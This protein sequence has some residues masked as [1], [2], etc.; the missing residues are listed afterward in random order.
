V[1]LTPNVIKNVK[2]SKILEAPEI[3]EGPQDIEVSWGSTAIFTCKV[4]GDPK[5]SIFWMR[6]DEEIALDSTKYT[7]MENGSLLIRNT[8]DSDSGH[9]ECMA[10]NSDGEVKSRAARMIL[11]R[12]EQHSRNAYGKY[13]SLNTNNVY[14]AMI[15]YLRKLLF[16][17]YFS[18]SPVFLVMPVGV[19]T[20]EAAS[21]IN[22][23]CKAVGNP[24]P[25]ITWSLNGVQ[26]TSSERHFIDR[27]GTLIIRPVKASDHGTY[28]CDATNDNGRISAIA[29]VIINGNF[30]NY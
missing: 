13:H 28:R 10:K 23:H 3:M 12:P 25:T 11:V 30:L 29:D 27:D 6:N 8:E 7:L 24:H 2:I 17:Y 15:L 4:S 21:E 9:Y 1:T 26:L 19:T 16:S 20:S 22:L 5:P 14:A 18:G